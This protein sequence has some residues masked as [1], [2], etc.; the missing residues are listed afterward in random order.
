MTCLSILFHLTLHAGTLNAVDF[1]AVDLEPTRG[2]SLMPPAVPN[3]GEVVA[4]IAR[5][6]DTLA[7]LWVGSSPIVAGAGVG[8]AAVNTSAPGGA[9]RV[10]LPLVPCTFSSAQLVP[11]RVSQVELSRCVYL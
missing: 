7:P 4:L 10:P 11:R 8:A 3:A 1:F 5:M 9:G 2:S 6:A